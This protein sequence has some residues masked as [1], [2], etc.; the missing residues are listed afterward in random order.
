MN[1]LDILFGQVRNAIE[2]HSSPNTPG[3]AY[4][5]GGILGTLA[6]IF[7]QHAQQRGEQF[8]GYNQNVLPA[9]QDPYGDPADQ[10]GQQANQQYGNVLPASQDPYGDPADQQGNVLPASQDPY[11]DPAD[12]RQSP[13]GAPGNH[14]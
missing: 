5:S 2:E 10:G 8:G 6:G 7:G 4:D 14:S 1:P 9:S 3:P 13:A 11:G 12:R